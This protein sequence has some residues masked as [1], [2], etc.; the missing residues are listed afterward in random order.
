MPLKH[1][2]S[3]LVTTEENWRRCLIVLLS[4]FSFSVRGDSHNILKQPW[5]LPTRPFSCSSV[6][7]GLVGDKG[8][9]L[10]WSQPRGSLW[11]SSHTVGSVCRI[12]LEHESTLQK[13]QGLVPQRVRHI[14]WG[15]VRLFSRERENCAK[16]CLAGKAGEG[17]RDFARTWSRVGIHPLPHE[18]P[19]Q[20]AWVWILV[21]LPPVSWI[22]SVPQFPPLYS[23]KNNN[24]CVKG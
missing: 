13:P 10:F 4:L 23:V 1:T 3:A 2:I 7:P 9:P 8:C 12:A 19:S 24:D 20:T 5:D 11:H 21:A 16:A 6:K 17:R 22:L 15:A 18:P 14:E